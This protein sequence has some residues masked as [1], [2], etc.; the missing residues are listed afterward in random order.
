MEWNYGW[1]KGSGWYKCDYECFRGWSQIWRGKCCPRWKRCSTKN[2]EPDKGCMLFFSVDWKQHTPFC[3]LPVTTRG[4]K[5]THTR[6][7][8]LDREKKACR[9]WWAI[10]R[11][12]SRVTWVLLQRCCLQI[13][14]QC[15]IGPTVEL[16]ENNTNAEVLRILLNYKGELPREAIVAH[17]NHMML[18][19]QHSG[20]D[21]KFREEVV[22]SAL[23]AYNRLLE[24]DASG[25][26]PLYRSRE[27]RALERER[28]RKKRRDNWFR[29][30]NFDIVILVPATPG[31][32][33]KCRY[34][35][36]IKATELEIKVV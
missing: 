28:E 36:E 21:R 32:Q 2:L 25:E 3:R 15:K 27:W 19:L 6:F 18:R 31:S 8:N 4:W 34:M 10:P 33:F 35:R 20:Y 30:W 14:D 17:V 23:A 24:L 16:Q 1:T 26:K 22:R 9:W 11:Y 7:Q 29:K 13:C 12:T 5:T